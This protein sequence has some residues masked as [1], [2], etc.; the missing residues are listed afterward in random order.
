M[1]PRTLSYLQAFRK[2]GDF[3]QKLLKSKRDAGK[4][5]DTGAVLPPEHGSA[6][7]YKL[8]VISGEP[9]FI[10]HR[11]RA[12]QLVD[13]ARA[14][15]WEANAFSLGEI[16][17]RPAHVDNASVLL[18]WRA[19]WSEVLEG[20]VGRARQSGARI[21]FDCDDLMF[22]PEIAKTAIIDGI[23]SQHFDEEQVRI[24]YEAVR[25]AA[26]LADFAV[27]PT[28]RLI[29][30]MAM[31][32]KPAYLLPN[33]FDSETLRLANASVLQRMATPPDGLLRVGYASGSRTHQR[34]FAIVAGALARALRARPNLRFVSFT[35]NLDLTEFPEFADLGGQIEWRT[36][37]PFDR[38]PS[39]LARFDV[40]LAPLEVD[41]PFCEAKSELK[42]FE[43]AL[44]G[45]PT[46]ASPTE[47]FR[48]AISDG[49]TGLLVPADGW[50]V[51]LDRVLDDAELRAELGRNAYRHVLWRYGPERR[52]ELV[53]RILSMA[54]SGA[55]DKAAFGALLAA[56]SRPW[57]QPGMEIPR[58]QV[59]FDAIGAGQSDVAVIMPVYNYAHYVEEALDSLLAQTLR[60]FDVVVVDDRSTD[61]SL[62]VV[63]AWAEQHHQR[64]TRFT[65]LRNECNSK[66]GPTRNVAFDFTRARF[67]MPLDAD[68]SLLPGCL[69]SCRAALESTGA[70]AAYPI[71]RQFG[72]ATNLMGDLPWDPVRLAH[73]NY[74]D[75]MAMI[76][77]AAWAALDG[78]EIRQGW[79]DYDLWLKFIERGFSAVQ[80]PE[81]LALYRVHAAS[82]IR[83]ETSREEIYSQL[84][85]TM[86]HHHPWSTI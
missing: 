75:A 37:V 13:A 76:R 86:Q 34:D 71:I 21:A 22:D 14:A 29:R 68:N 15:G 7:G 38:L 11:Y 59:V 4:A 20:I 42:Y 61:N 72:D 24:H 49:I 55:R 45:V 53:H 18:I 27:V 5:D 9:N 81:E 83:T 43:A 39:E 67:V 44:V 16:G 1:P 54:V 6:G 28:K 62:A 77:K 17:A 52:V 63:R 12:I 40:N 48:E 64:F 50:T 30:S 70:A 10:G 19:P 57:R 47:P 36:P 69:E 41:N 23:R 73:G 84:L 3:R 25:R 32:G 74:I 8:V 56:E 26:A 66:L 35:G 46:L 78:Y 82:M 31:L 2:I 58:S 80:V 60:N 51:A 85:R 65:L 33:G 79:E